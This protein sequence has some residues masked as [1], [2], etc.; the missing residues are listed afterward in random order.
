MNLSLNHLAHVLKKQYVCQQLGSEH[1]ASE[2]RL[3]VPA[4]WMRGDA[5]RRDLCYV[6]QAQ[7]IKPGFRCPPDMTLIVVGAVPPEVFRGAQGAV[8]DEGIFD[9]ELPK[10]TQIGNAVP[11]ELAYNIGRNFVKLLEECN[12]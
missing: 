4:L 2:A 11:V 10:Y 7:Q 8:L 6:V 9:R 5:P 12:A 1:A 3:C